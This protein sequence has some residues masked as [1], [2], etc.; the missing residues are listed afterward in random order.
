VKVGD[1]VWLHGRPKDAW[2]IGIVLGEAK[3]THTYLPGQDD[4]QKY[5]VWMDSHVFRFT[6]ENLEVISESE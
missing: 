5:E 4:Y 6:P 2:N 3:P 1:L